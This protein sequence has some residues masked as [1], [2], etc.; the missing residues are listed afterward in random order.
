MT[1]FIIQLSMFK[2]PAPLA[3]VNTLNHNKTQ[4]SCPIK[5]RE[6]S[7]ATAHYKSKDSF[8]LH[9]QNEMEKEVQQI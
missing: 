2:M 7:T 6:T 4:L 3:V 1:Q 8:N 9:H 5:I